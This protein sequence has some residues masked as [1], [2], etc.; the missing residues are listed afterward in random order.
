MTAERRCWIHLP[1]KLVIV[2][3]YSVLSEMNPVEFINCLTTSDMSEV[4]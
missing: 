3:V 2:V 1:M 4:S